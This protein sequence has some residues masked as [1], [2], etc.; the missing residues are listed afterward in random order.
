MLLHIKT[1]QGKYKVF[2]VYN[3][4][5][6]RSRKNKNINKYIVE[7]KCNSFHNANPF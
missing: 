1:K 3:N 2:Y 4:Y 6:K 5:G 7:W